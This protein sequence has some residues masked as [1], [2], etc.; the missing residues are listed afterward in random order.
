MV[1]EILLFIAVAIS[2]AYLTLA[3]TGKSASYQGAAAMYQLSGDEKLVL[4]R[5]NCPWDGRPTTLRFAI[6]IEAAPKTIAKVDCINTAT[7]LTQFGPSCT[8]YT[9]K[10]CK[11]NGASC[12]GCAIT[13]PYLSKILYTG[14]ALE[15][16]ASGY[17]SGND[18]PLV[19]ALLKIKTATDATQHFVESLSLPAIPLQRWT[20][21]TIVKEGR[22]IDVYYGQKAVASKLCDNLPLSAASDGWKAGGMNGWK[23]QIGLFTGSMKAKTQDDI[24]ADVEALV[25]TRGIPFYLDQINFSFDLTMPECMFG[26]CNKL[27]EVKPLNPF[28]VY[29]SSVQ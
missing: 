22:R 5:E 27:P 9:F 23:G 17:T 26:G 21:V 14:D 12:T 8:D 10:T 24:N 7:P 25:N 3:F 6:Y 15:L 28:A 16:W 4:P 18:K 13:S 29:N 11:C 19:P 2:I 20:V 1:T